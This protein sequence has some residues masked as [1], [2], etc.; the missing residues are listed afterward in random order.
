MKII[1]Y[2]ESSELVRI[3]H[4]II[5]AIYRKSYPSTTRKEILK[6]REEWENPAYKLHYCPEETLRRTIKNKMNHQ[7]LNKYEKKR[8][9]RSIM[10][11]AAPSSNLGRVNSNREEEGME[12]VN[13]LDVEELQ[14][15]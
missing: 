5:D 14:E 1:A 10:L 12:I 8:L 9:Y 7:G 4:E 3:K 6:K 2:K 13:P 15:Q 11:G